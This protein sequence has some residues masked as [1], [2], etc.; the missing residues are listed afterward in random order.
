MCPSEFSDLTTALSLWKRALI[1]GNSE[2]PE[3]T[4][5][6]GGGGEVIMFYEKCW[7]HWFFRH[8]DITL[9]YLRI[10]AI[11]LVVFLKDW[12]SFNLAF[13]SLPRPL[14]ITLYVCVVSPAMVAQCSRPPSSSVVARRQSES[15]FSKS[16]EVSWDA[17]WLETETLSTLENWA[18]TLCASLSCEIAKSVEFWAVFFQLNR[19]WAKNDQIFVTLFI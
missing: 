14:K 12:S 17:L 1:L 16:D 5:F 2:D 7:S 6:V 15:D 19:Q 8:K 10:V 11:N 18:A 4:W 3:H 9:E 13:L